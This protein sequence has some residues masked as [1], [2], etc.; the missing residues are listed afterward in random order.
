MEK[1]QGLQWGT[2]M[3]HPKSYITIVKR[4][5]HYLVYGDTIGKLLGDYRYRTYLGKIVFKQ[6]MESWY[7]EKVW[8][9]EALGEK[10]LRQLSRILSD[11]NKK[12]EE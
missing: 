4:R 10:C 6:G 7:Y 8:H 12:L 5:G 11:L 9:L 3:K 2:K 1:T